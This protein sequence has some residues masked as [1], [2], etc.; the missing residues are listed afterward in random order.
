MNIITKLAMSRIRAQKA[1]SGVICAA[2]FLT[3]VLFMTVVSISFNIIDSY[4]Q[5]MYLDWGTDYHGM[6][7]TEAFTLLPE[8]LKDRVAD[9]KYVRNAELVSVSD[10]VFSLENEESMTRFFAQIEEGNFPGSPD[11]ILVNGE[12][13]PD[14]KIGDS[15][16]T[17]GK[18]CTVSG[19]FTSRSQKTMTA[20]LLMTPDRYAGSSL[21]F[22][23]KNPLNLADKY[24]FLLHE[25]LGDCW[26]GIPERIGALNRAYLQ[27]AAQA[28]N[29]GNV[30]LMLFSVLVVSLCSFLLIYNVY[31]IALTQDMQTFGLLSVIGTTHAQL[32]KI[33]RTETGIL[34]LFSLPAGLSAGYLIGWKLLSPLMFAAASAEADLEFCFSPWIA[35]LTA[36][37]TLATLLYS[38]SRPLKKLKSLTPVATVDYSPAADLPLKYIRKKNHT[39]K[40][41]VPD[42][43]RLAGYT[44][45]RNRRKTLITALSVSLSVI[46]LV[47]ISTLCDYMITYTESQ[48]MH[49]DYII[50]PMVTYRYTNPVS[51][52]MILPADE[53]TMTAKIDEGRG[54]TEDFIRSVETLDG[55]A[56]VWR[57]RTAVTQI[58]TPAH[59]IADLQKL[60]EISPE[61]AWSDRLQEALN[62]SVSCAVVSIPD[63]LFR[64]LR[65]DDGST[66]GKGYESGWVIYENFNH[67]ISFFS[68]GDTVQLGNDG[69][70]VKDI[71]SLPAYRITGFL[72]RMSHRAVLY[73]PESEFFR[74]FGEG[75]TFMLLL[76][77]DD[78]EGIRDD[79]ESLC[80]TIP[81]EVDEELYEEMRRNYREEYGFEEE[82]LAVSGNIT[83]R[84][85]NLEEIR[86]A[87][88]SLRTVGY[89]LAAMIFLIG[90]LNIVN[91]SLSSAAER[92]REFAM[93]EAVGMTDR[94]MMRMLLTESLYSGGAA[95]LITAGIGF[96]LIALIVNTAMDALVSLHWLSGVIMLAVCIAVSVL[97]GLAVFRL[98]KSAAV[99][100]RIKVE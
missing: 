68:E 39:K 47:L 54:L 24:D 4:V 6:F 61:Y 15:I 29:P 22:D 34:Y 42:P 38:A 86:K 81:L 95:V 79:L 83:G 53:Y 28:F 8:E 71:G 56:E 50:E 40:Q 80:Q 65:C 93:L 35:V 77:T 31:S 67:D 36:A 73:L 27:T 41:T 9:S 13:Y 52:N 7:L 76:N 72:N 45:S 58:P 70:R 3:M 26:D 78:Y 25:E 21:Y 49:A 94:Q 82:T 69:Y 17:N 51:D 62:G 63:E 75:T 46:L 43:R 19:I 12:T 14:A 23:M 32:K 18:T 97:S 11:E 99:V 88:V 91:T 66:I 84:Y 48:I 55:V 5:L 57:I 60:R 100:E 2:I 20:I 92:K 90:A 96:P 44:L 59:T 37:L 89:S 74:Q 10:G 98:T 64:H 87:V 85:D 30:A 1:R 33:I 16:E